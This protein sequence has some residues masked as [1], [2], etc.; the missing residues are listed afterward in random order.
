MRLFTAPS[1]LLLASPTMPVSIPRIR[2]VFREFMAVLAVR[3]LSIVKP[4]SVKPCTRSRVKDFLK[5][6]HGF[7]SIHN[8]IGLESGDF[9]KSSRR[10]FNSANGQSS[11]FSLVSH[12]LLLRYPAHVARLIVAIIID[13][14]ER[15]ASG[16]TFAYVL[17]ICGKAIHP[18]LANLNASASI[19]MEFMTIRIQAS[20]LHGYPSAIHGMLNFSARHSVLHIDSLPQVITMD[21]G[22]MRYVL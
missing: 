2:I 20:L 7:R 14:V 1:V 9:S 4:C 12:L 8:R 11:G 3:L 6:C 5:T 22:V 19:V 13:A 15:K 16:G 10:I 21:G 17:D 18:L